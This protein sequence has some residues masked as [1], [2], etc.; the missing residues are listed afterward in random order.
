VPFFWSKCNLNG[1][2]DHVWIEGLG[3]VEC[4]SSLARWIQDFQER[5]LLLVLES[6]GDWGLIDGHHAHST[7]ASHGN[8]SGCAIAKG[9]GGSVS[10]L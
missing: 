10:G 7:G 6:L 5:W 1:R 9:Q 3:A 4:S 2:I 8:I